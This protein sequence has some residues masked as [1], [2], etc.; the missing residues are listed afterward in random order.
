MKGLSDQE[1]RLY[2]RS[3]TSNDDAERERLFI[4]QPEEIKAW[5]LGNYDCGEWY[6][7][8]VHIGTKESAKAQAKLLSYDVYTGGW[9]EFTIAIK[10]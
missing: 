10:P 9:V 8:R 5:L 2:N 1:K 3:S 6:T 4:K 7:S